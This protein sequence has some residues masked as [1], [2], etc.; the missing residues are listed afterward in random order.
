MA[1]ADTAKNVERTANVKSP[2][3]AR[4]AACLQ[5][6]MF[7]LQENMLELWRGSRAQEK[8]LEGNSQVLVYAGPISL[9]V[10]YLE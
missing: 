10:P 1:T 6:A 9:A 5:R 7:Y 8:R 4:I 2:K 3:S